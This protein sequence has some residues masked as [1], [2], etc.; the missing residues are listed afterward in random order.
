MTDQQQ[1][2][3]RRA[4]S[5]VLASAT[6]SAV[7]LAACGSTHAASS[8]RT[9]SPPVTATAATSPA[10]SPS[11]AAVLTI[12][13]AAAAYIKIIDPSNR[14]ADAVGAD[15]TDAAP[16]SQFR[17][18]TLAYAKS[19]RV[20]DTKL[21]AVRWPATV[22]PWVTAMIAT[23]DPA[24]IACAKAEAAALS[25]AAAVTVANSNQACLVGDSDPSEIRALLKLP[26]LPS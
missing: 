6:L 20:I 18:D 8:A 5:M 17:A 14:I 21:R 10:P 22:Q 9:A 16:F 19:V 12:K 2:R 15:V 4:R 26:P 7:A 23:Y 1:P 13:Q 25:N 11:P 24:Q 3:H